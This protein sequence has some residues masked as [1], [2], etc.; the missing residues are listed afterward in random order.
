MAEELGLTR[1]V[2]SI[3]SC[4]HKGVKNT[5]AAFLLRCLTEQGRTLQDVQDK[6]EEIDAM[7][8]AGEAVYSTQRVQ[9]ILNEIVETV[10]G[11]LREDSKRTLA[12]CEFVR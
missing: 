5:A 11:T 8:V 1:D 7:S 3:G 4:L 12:L 10:C 2:E 9:G 6:L